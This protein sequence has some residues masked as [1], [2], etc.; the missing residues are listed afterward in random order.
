MS[1]R[2]VEWCRGNPLEGFDVVVGDPS[3]VVL[4]PA[5]ALTVAV[6]IGGQD[7]TGSCGS[8]REPE[9][10]WDCERFP[11]HPWGGRTEWRTRSE[12][13]ARIGAEGPTIGV[14]PISWARDVLVALADGAAPSGSQVVALTDPED[15]VGV[16]LAV[17]SAGW[18]PVLEAAACGVPYVAVDLGQRDHPVRASG[19]VEACAIAIRERGGIEADLDDD[20]VP[21]LPD[22]RPSFR[23]EVEKL[24]EEWSS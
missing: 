12:V 4:A 2:S 15:L 21:M 5:E 1:W 13:R 22:F 19:T 6:A 8:T 20:H 17:V 9:F 23:F 7:P 10:V 3:V 11:L 16:D 24:F 14:L 18:A